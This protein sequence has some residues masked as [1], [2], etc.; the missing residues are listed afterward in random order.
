MKICCISDIHGYLPEVP[1]CDLLLLGGDYAPNTSTELYWLGKVF[2][3][4]IAKL[5]DRMKVIGV[6]GNHDFAFERMKDSLPAIQW[7]YLQDSG[8]EWKGL[9]IWGSPWQPRF[10]DWAFNADEDKLEIIWNQIP[11]NTDILLLHGPPRGYGDYSPYSKTNVGS[12]SLTKRILE[13]K[14]KLVV[15]GH[16]HPSYGRYTIGEG[17]I[18]VNASY[19]NDKYQPANDPWLI[20]I[21]EADG[22]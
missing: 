5:S 18:F 9:N 21:E 4:W 11:N 10:Y 16:I 15:A 22:N 2:A 19:V 1:E 3:P 8:I 7:T 12:P 13:I 17:T 20:E 6:A 14:P